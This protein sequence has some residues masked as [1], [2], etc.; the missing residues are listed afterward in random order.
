[1][2]DQRISRQAMRSYNALRQSRNRYN[3]WLFIKLFIYVSLTIITIIE[4][5]YDIPGVQVSGDRKAIILIYTGLGILLMIE[6]IRFF[7]VN[8]GR[9]PW[10]SNIQER[11]EQREFDRLRKTYKYQL[12]AK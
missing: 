2:E 1:M 6:V 5:Y 12:R 10:L 4:R 7:I 11:M 8:C 3:T 9:I